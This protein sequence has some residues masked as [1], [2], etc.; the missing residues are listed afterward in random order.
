MIDRV[1][2]KLVL[3]PASCCD[4]VRNIDVA[5]SHNADDTLRISHRVEG[6]I[7]R[8]RLPPAAA[9]LRAD[10]LWQHSCFEVFLRVEGADTY[11]EYNLAPS[12]AWACYRFTGPRRGRSFPPTDAPGIRSE[13]SG[14]LYVMNVTIPIAGLPD[15]LIAADLRAGLAAVIE[16]EQGALSYWALAHGAAEPDFH[17]PE[18]FTLSLPAT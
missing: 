8:L 10:E 11:Y 17:D 7:G 16:D 5:I 3:H 6:D 1:C 9:P 12:G 18:T 15:R 2:Q 4:A 13:R 14:G